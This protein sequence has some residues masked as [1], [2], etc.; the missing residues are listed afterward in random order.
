MEQQDRMVLVISNYTLPTTC[1]IIDH[2]VERP[3]NAYDHTLPPPFMCHTLHR[4][5]DM[6]LGQRQRNSSV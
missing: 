2:M 6:K 4:D 1:G 3:Y 5:Q